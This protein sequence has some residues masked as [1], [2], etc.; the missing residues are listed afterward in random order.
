M[1]L[2]KHV[3]PHVNTPYLV[4]IT[5]M[6]SPVCSSNKTRHE[7]SKPHTFFRPKHVLT[8]GVPLDSDGTNGRYNGWLVPQSGRPVRNIMSKNCYLHYRNMRRMPFFLPV[9]VRHHPPVSV[10]NE[11][12]QPGQRCAVPLPLRPFPHRQALQSDVHP[13]LLYTSPSPR[14]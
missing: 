11:V 10:R 4:M 7:R 8:E 12:V 3:F 9:C 13:C 6:C 5:V 1:D 2:K 14:D